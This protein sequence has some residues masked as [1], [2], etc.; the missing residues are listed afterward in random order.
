MEARDMYSKNISD[1]RRRRTRPYPT[2]T[3]EDALAIARTIQERNSGLPF[4]RVML[5]RAMGTTEKSS[6]FTIKLNSSKHY[7]LTVGSYKDDLISL[8]ELGESVV[9]PKN[10]SEVRNAL[11]T[12][13]L[14]PDLFSQFYAMMQGRKLPEDLYCQ[15]TLHRELRIDSVL[16]H[17][18]LS[19][20]KANGIFTNILDV[21]TGT[22]NINVAN[23]KR[24]NTISESKYKTEF[25]EIEQ[26]DDTNTDITLSAN[27]LILQNGES[28]LA[29]FAI[30][31]LD[32]FGIGY[33]YMNSRLEKNLPGPIKIS[34]VMRSCNS[35]ILFFE[36][37]GIKNNDEL[38]EVE[39]EILYQLGV[40]TAL[41][42]DKVVIIKHSTMKLSGFFHGFNTV[43][44]EIGKVQ[45]S[46]LR[47]LH[48]LHL[49][50]LVNV[51]SV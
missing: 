8:T 43:D 13:A 18:C 46:G 7:G 16:T 15:N 45:E 51:V 48:Q 42:G 30:S 9:A 20:I 22:L 14:R 4:D 35:G 3:L 19:I 34:T 25:K 12:A 49:A 24:N 33:A 37:D 21:D 41:Y 28:E 44:Y 31:V 40:L 11:T 6:G 50:G 47:F 36:H 10:E 17:E 27:I 39:A 38:C 23:L 29:Q 32:K 1:K 2:N 5:A 26:K